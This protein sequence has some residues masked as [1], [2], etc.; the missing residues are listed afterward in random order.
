M[1]NFLLGLGSAN[2]PKFTEADHYRLLTQLLKA[3]PKSKRQ[4]EIRKKLNE[5]RI[6]LG[7]KP[8]K[9]N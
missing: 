2:K 6:Y 3:F 7:Y 5:V 1:K 4:Q 9:S 8:L